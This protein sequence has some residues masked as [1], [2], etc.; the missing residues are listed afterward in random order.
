MGG[1]FATL[2]M[3]RAFGGSS[4]ASP[5]RVHLVDRARGERPRPDWWDNRL[6]DWLEL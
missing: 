6:A 3:A 2:K 5:H 4:V 1:T